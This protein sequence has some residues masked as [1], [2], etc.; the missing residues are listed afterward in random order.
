MKRLAYVA[1]SLA[2]LLSLT[3]CGEM[4]TMSYQKDVQSG[5]EGLPRET[6]IISPFTGAVL[7]T[8]TGMTDIQGSKEVPGAI[9]LTYKRAD[10]QVKRTWVWGATVI[11]EEQ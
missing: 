7:G 11:S 10:G 9:I 6:R 2:V 4:S 1:V 5:R 3:A 8:Y